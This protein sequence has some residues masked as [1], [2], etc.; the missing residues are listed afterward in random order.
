M[1][2]H[3]R[4]S[5]PGV[6]RRSV[7]KEDGDSPLDPFIRAIEV[8]RFDGWVGGIAPVALTV[9][10]AIVAARLGAV[11]ALAVGAGFAVGLLVACLAW[12]RPRWRA[13]D[14]L[15]GYA[16]G[17]EQSWRRDTGG[18]NPTGD[19]V[20]AEVWLGV[21]KAGT[22]PQFYRAIAAGAAADEHRFGVELGRMTDGT[23]TDRALKLFAVEG[24]RFRRSGTADIDELTTLVEELP[25]SPLRVDLESWL[26]LVK[27]KRRWSLGQPDW[28]EPLEA[29]QSRSERQPLPRGRRLRIW[30]GRLRPVLVFAVGSLVLGSFAVRAAGSATIRPEYE[31]T[32]YAIRGDLPGL[33][34]QALVRA[35]P[36]LEQALSSATRAVE[37]PLDEAAFDDVV[38]N[39]LPTLLWTTGA[40]EVAKPAD[41]GSHR[42][43]EIEVLLGSGTPASA[44]VTFDG[45]SGPRYLYRIDAAA[46]DAVRAA[47]GL[48][49][50]TGN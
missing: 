6:F 24:T 25:R 20:A 26:A 18:P 28:L 46:F 34:D 16:N 4:L 13:Q 30:V 29:E 11:P 14:V 3:R 44:I 21:H 8:G 40:I 45:A 15:H 39:S 5:V 37:G 41:A 31:R 7:A 43:W 50:A 36:G 9:V 32:T 2:L 1:R 35:L 12:Q 42:V 23:P 22:V 49:P 33:D 19:P 38:S 27:S 10:V 47:G 17:R 48:P